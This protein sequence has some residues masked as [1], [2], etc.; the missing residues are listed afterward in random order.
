MYQL[1]K[2]IDMIDFTR[3]VLEPL[4]TSVGLNSAITERSF[5]QLS[6][7]EFKRV[8][9]LSYLIAQPLCAWFDEL[10][11]GLDA[12]GKSV[13]VS[14]IN[15]KRAQY[16]ERMHVVVTHDLDCAQALR[17]DRVY[18]LDDGKISHI[19][20]ADLITHYKTGASRGL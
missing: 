1:H 10:D 11:S 5:E 17:A 4:A 8:E 9:L 6:G 3:V 7:G 13:F 14:L 12:A 19:G 16:P 15:Q 20:S 2:K 18:I